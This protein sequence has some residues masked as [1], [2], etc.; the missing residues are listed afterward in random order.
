MMCTDCDEY[1]FGGPST[2]IH[3][4]AGPPPPLTPEQYDVL[5]DIDSIETDST[6]AKSR[7]DALRDSNSTQVV[8]AARS[9]VT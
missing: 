2:A 7:F 6:V 5:H 8:T 9:N 1:R 4:T 3:A